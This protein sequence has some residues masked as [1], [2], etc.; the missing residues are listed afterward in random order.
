M[1]SVA[2]AAILAAHGLTPVAQFACR[3]RNRIALQGDIWNAGNQK[4]EAKKVL[5]ETIEAVCGIEG[6]AGVHLMGYRNDVTLA[7]AI[8]DLGIRKH[9]VF[10]PEPVPG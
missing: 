4:A 8:A 2:G 1:S 9:R 5:V 6:V 7:E 3:D 10:I